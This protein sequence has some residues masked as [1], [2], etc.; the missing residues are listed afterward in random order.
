MSV[1]GVPVSPTMGLKEWAMLLS[2]SLLW[3]GSFFFVGVA[4]QALPPLTIVAARVGLAAPV[5]WMAVFAL[6]R[7]IPRDPAVWAAF[8]VMGVLNNVIPFSLIVWGQTQIPSGLASI[9]NATT[10]L[11]TVVVAGLLLA[12]ERFSAHKG[13][14]V[15]IGFAGVVVL[16]GADALYVPDAPV[17]AQMAVLG[18]GLSYA[19]AAVFGR[20]FRGMGLDPLVTATGQVTFSGLIMVA[21]AV[22]IDRPWTLPMPAVPVLASLLGLAVLCTALAYGL[23]FR[24]LATAGATNV[25]LVTF[26]VPVTA[27]LLGVTVL[28][29][30]LRASHLVGMAVIGAGL[31]V[32]DGRVLRR[33]A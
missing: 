3:G 8:A 17:L 20:R 24:I 15:A 32:M 28:D 16:I 22:G 18:A 9:L 1:A 23:Y 11:F 25:I 33:V 6:R 21:L 26:L 10:P 19:F 5:L 7:P 31:L 30:S 4:V 12:D 29:E 2:L 14:G 27:I 13:L